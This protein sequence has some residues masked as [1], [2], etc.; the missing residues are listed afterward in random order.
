MIVTV[1][2]LCLLPI[3]KLAWPCGRAA[4]FLPGKPGDKILV[5]LVQALYMQAMYIFPISF[6]SHYHAVVNGHSDQMHVKHRRWRWGGHG[7]PTFMGKVCLQ[8]KIEIL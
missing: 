7:P 3:A 6:D 8:E 1:V 2:S 4:W 5:L